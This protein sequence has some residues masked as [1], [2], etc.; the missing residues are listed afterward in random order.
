MVVNPA[1]SEHILDL[2]LRGLE[3]RV[4]AKF[5]RTREDTGKEGRSGGEA[6]QVHGGTRWAIVRTSLEGASPI[7]GYPFC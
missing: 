2:S 3:R 5:S 6:G 4:R 7:D 1:V